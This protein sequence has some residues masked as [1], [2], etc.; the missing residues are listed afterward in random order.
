MRFSFAQL[1]VAAAEGQS[2]FMLQLVEVRKFSL[3]V[4]QFVFQPAAHRRA[5]LHA[6]AS[7][8]QKAADLAELKSESLNS[9]NESQ[10]FHIVFTVLAKAPLRPRGPR[11]Q[12]TALVKA[13]RVN[14]EADLFRHHAN[15][16]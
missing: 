7:Q 12:C 13:N 2:Q 5:R 4:A 10:C 9:A 15:L 14:A 1:A 3:H 16:H 11:E 8:I 6:A